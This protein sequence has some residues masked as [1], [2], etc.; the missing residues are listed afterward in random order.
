[1][2]VKQI[3]S[4]DF[5]RR[6]N[7][8]WPL[9][10]ES[11][12][13]KFDC[14]GRR[15]NSSL[16]IPSQ[17]TIR[18]DIVTT[19][20]DIKYTLKRFPLVQS[21]LNEHYG[22]LVLCGGSLTANYD[23]TGRDVGSVADVDLF[24]HSCTQSE[25]EAILKSCVLFLVKNYKTKVMSGAAYA[26]FHDIKVQIEHKLHVTNVAIQ[27]LDN[28]GYDYNHTHRTYQFIHRIYPSLGSILGGFDLG[29]SM[30]AY[31]GRELLATE[32][33]AWSQ[34][35]ATLIVDI[36]RRSTTFGKRIMKYHDR[37]FD[38]VLPGIGA[39]TNLFS[40]LSKDE[41][42]SKLSAYMKEIGLIFV[43]PDD[44]YSNDYKDSYNKAFELSNKIFLKDLC[45]IQPLYGNRCIKLG[46]IWNSLLS[47]EKR[48]QIESD[49]G[50]W[51]IHEDDF[52][53]K[54]NRSALVNNNLDYVMV[55]ICHDDLTDE[56]GESL[57]ILYDNMLSSPKIITHFVT[58][59]Y[60][61]PEH[62]IRKYAEYGK[63][64]RR[65]NNNVMMELNERINRNIEKAKELLKG[66]TWIAQEPGRQWTSSIN[67]EIIDARD[68]YGKYYTPFE[69]GIDSEI[70][71]TIRLAR[72]C[73][74]NL[75][76]QIPKDITNM[77]MTK[78][79]ML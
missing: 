29:P 13:N 69:I 63:D 27:Y 14:K 41:R 46:R 64:G 8:C 32:L 73:A 1:M 21:L 72:T 55:V 44:H 54:F 17:T 28:Q 10:P 67:P 9:I 57:D 58:T 31:D 68:F 65:P 15:Y 12:W 35:N 42:M 22:K 34:I 71:T 75:W 16:V 19:P 79:A 76:S 62:L 77:I 50:D 70:E 59:D 40:S 3:L 33:G 37:G 25:A 52:I 23:H 6:K 24:F 66:I 47:E 7:K 20:Y 60:D 78:L 2:D 4:I 61:D 30:V 38:V 11:E 39:N 56:D 18:G 45:L 53:G 5:V 36:S 49:Y 74:D 26:N 51:Q 43:Q 48:M